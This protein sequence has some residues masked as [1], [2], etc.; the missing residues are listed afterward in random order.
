MKTIEPQIFL[1]GETKVNPIEVKR[2]LKHIGAEN[3]TTD[4]TTDIE[5]LSELFGRGCYKS[6]EIG[7]NPNISKIRKG[8]DVYLDNILKSGHGSVL[9]HV[10]LNW[11]FCDVSRVPVPDA[12][13]V[14][15][16]SPGRSGGCRA[17]ADTVP[18]TGRRWCLPRRGSDAGAPGVV[19]PDHRYGQG[20]RGG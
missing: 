9:E 8:N 17:G 20:D 11:M 3:W 7:L 13:R 10:W 4:A 15:P 19:L 14:P 18:G 12:A 1:I 6:Y 5:Y 16:R 2:Y